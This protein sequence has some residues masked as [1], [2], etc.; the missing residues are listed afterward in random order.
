MNGPNK[1]LILW[2]FGTLHPLESWKRVYKL[3]V[4][5]ITT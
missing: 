5:V 4:K 1:M 2:E 3:S